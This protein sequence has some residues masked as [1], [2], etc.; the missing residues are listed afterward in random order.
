LLQ[1]DSKLLAAGDATAGGIPDFALAR[2]NSDGSLD[3][4][5]SGD[6]IVTTPIGLNSD[7]A[8][9]AALQTNGR[10]VLVG[11]TFNYDKSDDF[12]LARYFTE[13]PVSST[14]T[15]SA[16][17][18]Q[19][20]LG[21]PVSLTGS[22]SF[23]DGASPAGKT[24]HLTRTNPD[25]SE[26]SLPD[27]VTDLQGDYSTA[28]TPPSLGTFTYTAKY[29]GDEIHDSATATADARVIGIAALADFNGDGFGDLAVGVPGEDVGAFVD[30][31]AVNIIYGS[32]A[33]LSSTNNQWFDQTAT[34]SAT[35]VSNDTFGWSSAAGDFNGDGYADLAVGVPFKKVG[36]TTEAGA[37]SLL[38]G[39][40]TGLS[41]V[42]SHMWD[43]N[44]LGTDPAETGDGFGAAVATGDVNGDGF[45]DLA[46]GVPGEGVGSKAGA[47]AVNI[48]L[49]S[50]TGLTATGTEFWNQD[51]SNINNTAETGDNFGLSVA[52]GDFDGNSFGDLAAGVPFENLTNGSDAGSVNVIY[53][54][55]SGLTST[56]DDFWN[57][58]VD[59]IAN[60]V[61]KDDW[62]GYSV[63]AG[64]FD[65]DTFDDLLVG[66][67]VES[68]SGGAYAGAANV[69][70]GTATGLD[71]P[72]D[73][74][75]NQDTTGISNDAE[76]DDNFAFAVSAG[77]F[78]ADGFD[79]AASGVPGEDLTGAADAGG[80][81]VIYGMSSGLNEAGDD[82]WH[83]NSSGILDS[84]E[85]TDI[86]GIAVTAADFGNGPEA[87][88]AA[89]VQWE[90]IGS[91]ADAGAAN[92]IYGS[93]SDLTS[94][95]NQFWH[96][97]STGILD[98]AEAND[99][100][101]WGFA[102]PGTGQAGP[103]NWKS[104]VW[105]R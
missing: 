79:D 98:Q 6:G 27:Q 11:Q 26:T 104:R 50:A 37:V 90:N 43:Q 95:N 72:G 78:D 56:A 17:P 10:V 8:F 62:F 41:A 28:D 73:Q 5:F 87:D 84:A 22:L 31:G 9:G 61:E 66:V 70:Y 75:W 21:D 59:G 105:P 12:A 14:L 91:I 83:Q 92:V 76:A 86:F 2:Y 35:D 25:S 100:F 88:L 55:A 103:A 32:A 47:G 97:D 7:S 4:T 42:N 102:E 89:G 67:P 34:G 63:A 65:G 99:V 60:K 94:T 93:P 64:D 15:V 1:T 77:D 38:Y 81:S 80:V 40:S 68:L 96:Q 13:P 19:V 58:D 23:A 69:I 29:D 39:S 101:G 48:L 57:Q 30:T 44:Q 52:I 24:I 46:V 18:E 71:D 36:S 85:K 74:F 51:S 3:P 16:E 49:G 53:G 20:N 33:G 45:A 54:S 82:F